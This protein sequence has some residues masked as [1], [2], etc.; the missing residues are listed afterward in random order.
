MLAAYFFFAAIFRT[1]DYF[2][3]SSLL[4]IDAF[5]AL[6]DEEIVKGDE[7]KEEELQFV[8]ES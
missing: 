8:V 4:K 1:I 5:P 7:E 6:W 3:I 2:F